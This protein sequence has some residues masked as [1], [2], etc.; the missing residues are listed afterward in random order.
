MRKVPFIIGVL[1]ILLGVYAFWYYFQ[2]LIYGDFIE[3][4][5]L[6]IA[7]LVVALLLISFGPGVIVWAYATS[8]QTSYK[9]I[10]KQ[11]EWQVLQIPLKCSE[12]QNEIS[13]RSLEWIGDDEARCPFCSKDL[14]I[15]SSRSYTYS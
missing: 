4:L 5:Y 15:K 3:Q 11:K 10:A 13:V 14:E 9:Q 2:I 6:W 8:Y 12:C 1:M 7:S